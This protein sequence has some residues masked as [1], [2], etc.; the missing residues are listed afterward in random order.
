LVELGGEKSTIIF[1]LPLDLIAPFLTAAAH[2]ESTPED[3]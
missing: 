1:P 2:Q 3:R